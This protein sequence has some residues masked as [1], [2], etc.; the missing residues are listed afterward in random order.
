M[1]HPASTGALAAGLRSSPRFDFSVTPLERQT[2]TWRRFRAWGD[3]GRAQGISTTAAVA[4]IGALTTLQPFVW[5]LHPGP[6]IDLV[7]V[8]AFIL[9]SIGA[10]AAPNA[11]IE[12]GDY[13]LDSRIPES[14]RKPI[15]SGIIQPRQVLWFVGAGVAISIVLSILMFPAGGAAPFTLSPNLPMLGALAVAALAV[16]WYGTGMGKGSAGSYD[17]AFSLAYGAF[18]LFGAFAVGTPTEWTWVWVGIIATAGTAF[19]Q[20]ENG[21]KDVAADRAVGVRSFAVLTGVRDG[22]RLGAGHPFLLYGIFLKAAFL[23][24]A[25]YAAF[26]FPPADRLPYLL[27]LVLYG[28]PSQVFLLWRFATRRRRLDAR[29]GILLDVTLTAFAGFAFT[30]GLVGWAGYLGLMAFLIVGYLVGSFCQYGTEFKFGRYEAGWEERI[31][32]DLES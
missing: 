6:G 32:R 3:L 20:W 18:V 12:L 31:A 1:A 23:F 16:M 15:V 24:F 28:V 27:L 30:A 7:D 9:V 4:I 13:P 17:Y 22:V 19:A 14:R 2:T 25:F 8:I 11:Y 26:L 21:L 10:H 5:R 29:R